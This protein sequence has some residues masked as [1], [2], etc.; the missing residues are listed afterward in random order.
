[1]SDALDA[2]LKELIEPVAESLGYE[3]VRVRF[4]AR[5]LQIMAERPDGRM[6][7]EDCTILSRAIAPVLDAADPIAEHYSLEVSSPG[8]DR[9]LTR[10]KDFIAWAGHETKVELKSTLAGRKRFRGTLKGLE[11]GA[12]VLEVQGTDGMNSVALPLDQIMEAKLVLT[13]ELLKRAE[14]VNEAEFDEV[15]VDEAVGSRE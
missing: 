13:D 4:K 14:P 9:P 7:I 8:I 15:K 1:L 11:G 3:L 6:L 2:R 12:A 5:T 10:P